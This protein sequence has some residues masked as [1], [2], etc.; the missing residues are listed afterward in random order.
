MTFGLDLQLEMFSTVIRFLLL[1]RF[2]QALLV[3]DLKCS[4]SC[5]LSESVEDH[6]VTLH[7]LGCV[8]FLDGMRWGNI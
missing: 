2:K 1:N 8:Y 3:L 4:S 6:P 7:R 5:V